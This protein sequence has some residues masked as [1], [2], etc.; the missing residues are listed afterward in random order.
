MEYPS[1]FPPGP[2]DD[3]VYGP[4]QPP[5]RRLPRA[6]IIGGLATGL[7]LSGAGIAYAASSSGGSSPGTAAAST[8]TSTVAPAT[9]KGP[10]RGH[11]GRFGFKAGGLGFPGLGGR[12]LYGQAT[13]E[14]PDGT[15]KT[16]E[17][18][19]GTVSDV[20][21][22]SITVA[23]G[24]YSHTYKVDS[25]T[26]VDSQAAGISSVSKGDQV[27]L[28]ATQKSGSDTAVN[29]VDITKVRSSRSGFGFGRG[30]GKGPAGSSPTTTPATGATWGGP[31][32]SGF[33]PQDG[34]SEIQ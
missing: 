2:D 20:S 21:G 34:P 4:L 12:V 17:F 27:Q 30:N 26:V 6:V 31:G 23:S 24:S 25:S 14:Q 7:A 29:I 32:G 19:S 15:T 3:P 9:P 11:P 8:P 22:S 1:Q 10:G 18:Q 33:D 28:L 5:R 16:V 13:I